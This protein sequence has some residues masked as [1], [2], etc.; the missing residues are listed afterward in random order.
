M[1][2]NI[3]ASFMIYLGGLF[4][5][6]QSLHIKIYLTDV[7]DYNSTLFLCLILD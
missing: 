3:E 2:F 4:D 5:V 7:A 1:S 6:L